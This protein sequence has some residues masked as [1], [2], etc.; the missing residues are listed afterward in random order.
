MF[1]SAQFLNQSAQIWDQEIHA[2]LRLILPFLEYL[3][4][5]EG[6]ILILNNPHLIEDMVFS[7]NQSKFNVNPTML[8]LWV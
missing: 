4:Q 1:L 3:L 2:P 8:L 7:P 5:L 6:I